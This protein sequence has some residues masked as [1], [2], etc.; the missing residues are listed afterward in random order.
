MSLFSSF[1]KALGFPE[2]YDDLDDLSDLEDLDESESAPAATAQSPRDDDDA[3]G[4]ELEI[5]TDAIMTCLR[6]ASG[7][8]AISDDTR[9]ELAS[10]LERAYSAMALNVRKR[11]EHNWQLEKADYNR[12]ISGFRKS[13]ADFDSQRRKFESDRLSSDRQKRALNDRISDM[14]NRIRDLEAEREQLLLENKCMVNKLRGATITA[15]LTAKSGNDSSKQSKENER[16]RRE[17][18]N[19]KRQLAFSEKRLKELDDEERPT[20]EQVKAIEEQIKRFEAVKESKDAEIRRLTNRLELSE[21]AN[22]ELGE[23]LSRAVAEIDEYKSDVATLNATIEANLTD[24]ALS[25]ASLTKEIARLKELLDS[26]KAPK[27][28]KRRGRKRK[29]TVEGIPAKPT[30]K[31]SAIDELMDNTDWFSAPEPGPRIKDPEVIE[32]FGYKEQPK[33]PSKKYDENQLTL[34]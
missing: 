15:D 27:E 8:A 25:Q 6:D 2:E 21:A 12:E 31:I 1:K 7:S 34:F 17:L 28:P 11:L 20:A 33:K 13:E 18:N 26:N 3:V 5:L 19:V 30:V 4:P 23:R 10:I 9:G 16:L 32:N 24:H 14:E 29:E 22:T